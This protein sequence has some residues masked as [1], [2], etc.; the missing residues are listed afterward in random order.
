MQISDL[1]YV[2]ETGFHSPDYPTVLSLLQ[3]AYREIY[4][5]DIY[6]TP[7]S[8]DGQWLAIQ[9]LA[10]FD[11]IQV[12]EAVYNSF[13]PATAVGAGLSRNVKI[14]GI[15]RQSPTH[16]TVDVTLTGQAGATIVAGVVSDSLGQQWELPAS[17]TI[18]VEGEIVVTA[19]AVE[20]GALSAAA[21]SI[22]R[23]ATPTRGWQT[24]TN[25][26]PATEGVA[27]ETDAALRRRQAISTALPSLSVFDGIVGGVA[28][29]PGVTRSRGYENDSDVTD[30]DGIPRHSI[31][32]VVEGGD[33][34]YVADA[35]ARRKTPGT[36]TYGTTTVTTFDA[37]GVP[38]PINFFRPT[39]VQIA[40][41]ITI[42]P[43]AGYTAPTGDAIVAA[44]TAYINGLDIGDDVLLTKLYVPANLPGTPVINTYDIM[45]I[46]LARAGQPL[47]PQ[48]II[49][50][51]NE[52]AE[53]LPANINV[54]VTT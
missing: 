16:S 33:A 8:Q 18:P 25:V 43:L 2:D 54:A 7:D 41:A 45:S 51:F 47:L 23:I 6:L 38:N 12:A 15:R 17:V 21:G 5:T 31:A 10:L 49:V 39:T 9:A 27:V 29:V 24:V 28:N 26:L 52:V 11:T 37:R 40:A 34:Q 48:N 35:I 14:N 4:G 50:A 32:L 19:T 30:A 44:V 36:G 3:D 1:V 22:T 46:T 42:R 20:L 53:A 13:S